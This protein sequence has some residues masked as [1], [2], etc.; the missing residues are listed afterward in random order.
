MQIIQEKSWCI[1]EENQTSVLGGSY[2]ENSK[3]K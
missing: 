2:S 1:K 3:K